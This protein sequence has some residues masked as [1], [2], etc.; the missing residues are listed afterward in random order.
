MIHQKILIEV[1]GKHYPVYIG[2]GCYT[3]PE[4]L[5][6]YL[7][8][9]QVL[10]VTQASIAQ[11][12][13]SPLQALLSGFQCDVLYLPEGEQYKNIEQWQRILDQ[14]FAEQHDRH[15]TLIALGGGVVGDITGFAAACYLRG[16]NYLH[17][18]TTLIAQ[19]DSAIG[20]KTAVNHTQGKNIIGAFHQPRCVIAD[21]DFLATL[22]M[23]EYV[24][25]LAEVVKYGLIHD[26]DFFAW[27]ANHIDDL[28]ARDTASLLHA[29][30]TSATIKAKFVAE[31]EKENDQ[32]RL[33]N[34]GHT[35]AHALEVANDYQILHGEAV[36]AGMEWATRLSMQM[37]WLAENQGETVL[38]LLRKLK[39][40]HST[41]KTPSAEMFIQHMRHDKK[42]QRGQVH[43]VLLKSIGQAVVT[44][45]I[46]EDQLKNLL[47]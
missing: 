46:T 20:G 23:R 30:S 34:F 26:A 1:P 16:V 15:T 44:G 9:K 25:G 31:D 24:A 33:L 22:P 19:V 28:L 13:L 43:F 37:G 39:Q 6:P 27:L 21:L 2:Q 12:Y 29:I 40:H 10:I 8:S 47:K 42:I 36:T 45:E 35:F 41:I 11:H 14:L 38:A 32:R 18:P 7:A 5:L 4:V 17:L 3:Q